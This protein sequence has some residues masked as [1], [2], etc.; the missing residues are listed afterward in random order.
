MTSLI[1]HSLAGLLVYS[2]ASTIKD[3]P[4]RFWIICL[5][6]PIIPDLDVI[7][8]FFEIPY[9]SPYGHRGFT[10]SI[11]FSITFSLFIGSFFARNQSFKTKMTFSLLFFMSLI[12]HTLLDAITN[13]GLGVAFFWPFHNDRYFLPWNPVQVSP[14]GIKAF[15]SKRGIDVLISEFKYVISPLIAINIMMILITKKFLG[16]KG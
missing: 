7:A 6:L 14:L 1:T 8:F 4:K 13:G 16:K 10:H 2:I 11:V 5:L 3:Y 15:I 9:S 12:S